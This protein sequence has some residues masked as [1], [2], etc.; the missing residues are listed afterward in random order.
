MAELMLHPHFMKKAQEELDAVVGTDRLVQE[1]DIANLPFLHAVVKE[2]FRVHPSTPLG[3][4]R[5]STAGAEVMGHHIPAKSSVTSTSLPF[6]EIPPSMR[7][8]RSSTRTGF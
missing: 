3:S 1:A 5:E 2:T 6:T 8:L 4:P 7:I